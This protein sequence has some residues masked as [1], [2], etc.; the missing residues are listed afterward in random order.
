MP[1]KRKQEVKVN[2][3]GSLEGIMQEAYNDACLQL[4]EATST[5]NELQTSANAETVDDLT[6]I[7]KEKGGLL[8][9]KDSA[10]RIKLELAKLQNEI[11]KSN[12]DADAAIHNATGGQV[13]DGD[14][15]AVREHL[16]KTSQENFNND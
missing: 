10:I 5:I 3:L 11:I 14:L 16:K 13:S 8:K 6:K 7:A 1:R 12:G 4:I 9:V 15:K 2:N